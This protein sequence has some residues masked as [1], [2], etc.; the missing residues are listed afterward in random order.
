MARLAHMTIPDSQYLKASSVVQIYKPLYVLN[1]HGTNKCLSDEG[2]TLDRNVS[3]HIIY[4]VQHIHINLKPGFHM[5]VT[6]VAIAEKSA[7]R[8]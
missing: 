2:L 5:I 8:S 1:Y 4:G 3:Q 6:I 7:Q